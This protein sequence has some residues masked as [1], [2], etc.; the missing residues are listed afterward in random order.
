VLDSIRLRLALWHTA[1]LAIVL[2]AFGVFTA[3]FLARFTRERERE[4]LVET[5]SIYRHAFEA[6]LDDRRTTAQ[7]AEHAAR[8]FRF[9][10]RCVL[11]YD[12]R[13]ELIALSDSAGWREAE[14][15]RDLPRSADVRGLAASAAARRPIFAQLPRG[16]DGSVLGYAE[17]V[18]VAGERF[19]IV[20]LQIRGGEREV[21]GDFLGSG[22]IA[23]PIALLLAG[24]G[25]HLLARRSL[26]PVLAMSERAAVI[27]SRSLDERLPVGNPRD[28]LGRL[29]TVFNGLL[30]R[31]ERAFTQ[32]RQF[33]ADASHELRTPVA[34]LRA[35]TE[36]ALSRQRSPQEY[37]ESLDVVRG[38]A[39]RLGGI[40]DN[41]FALARADAGHLR[42]HRRP[43]FL[44]ELVADTVRSMR[45]LARAR[46]ITLEFSPDTDVPCSGDD[47]LLRHLVSNLL[48]NAIKYTPAGG[49]VSVTLE[50]HDGMCELAVHDTGPGIPDALRSRIF[51]RFVRGDDARARSA[52][53]A[54]TGAGLGL[55]IA[56]V[57]AEAH[58][59]TIE[60]TQ[61][62]PP[63]STFTLRLPAS[64]PGRDPEVAADMADHG[65]WVSR[66]LHHAYPSEK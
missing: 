34:I 15:D 37:R 61:T 13:G 38:A 59:G 14:D 12:D 48:D 20:A 45:T 60:L 8:E 1:T 19:V 26:A 2:I 51:E 52:G 21:L 44:E 55:A 11:V 50:R 31:L 7:A 24:L 33:V 43:L 57:I 65:V 4:A 58:G 56:R 23:I 10:G 28:E 17:P 66:P 39:V 63:G 25:G 36:V 35:E 49:R 47:A 53:S 22:A 32:Q 9:S 6:E 46:R 54:T 16:R 29:A 40:V 27:G 30:E 5:A 62:G 42:L 3:L 64:G 41:L 18:R